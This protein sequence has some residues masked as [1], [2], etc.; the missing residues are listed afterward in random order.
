[1]SE[2]KKPITSLFV[3]AREW[4]DKT[5]GNSYFSARV[6]VDGQLVGFLPF[7]YG[8]GSQFE[9]ATREYLFLSGYDVSSNLS[10]PLYQLASQGVHVYSVKYEANKRDVQRFG[11]VA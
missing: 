7:Q 1:M 11:K 5:G 3:E 6:S 8:Y 4:F 2:N 9:T 10:A